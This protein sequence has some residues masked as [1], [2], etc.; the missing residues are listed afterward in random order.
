MAILPK[1]TIKHF[2][3]G[4]NTGLDLG[5]LKEKEEELKKRGGDGSKNWIQV[6]KIDKPLDVRIL[7][8]LPSMDGVYFVEVP[9]WW[10]NG[11]RCISSIHKNTDDTIIYFKV[12]MLTAGKSSIHHSTKIS[13]CTQ[14]D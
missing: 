7:N 8:P 13:T 12:D 5:K 9:V 3:M 10:I 14:L 2:K 1:T 11:K 4:N 6:S